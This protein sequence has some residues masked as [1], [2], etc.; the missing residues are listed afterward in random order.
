MYSKH[1]TV[2]VF[3]AGWIYKQNGLTNSVLKCNLFVIRKLA[4]LACCVNTS[5]CSCLQ[6]CEYSETGLISLRE[7]GKKAGR[8]EEFSAQPRIQRQ[9]YS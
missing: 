7:T 3:I 5:T 1:C 4:V 6:S 9:F 2:H 8:A